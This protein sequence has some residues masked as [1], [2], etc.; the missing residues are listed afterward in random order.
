[1]KIISQIDGKQFEDE[2]TFHRSLKAHGFT[3]EKYYHKFFPKKDLFSGETLN[4]RTKEQY[5]DNDFNSKDN[6]KKWL[7]GQSDDIARTYCK[8]ILSKRKNNK[9]I[10]YSPSQVELRTIMSPSILYY[11]KLFGDYYKLCCELGFRNK[12]INVDSIE[13]QFQNKVTA[14]STIYVDSREQNWLKFD[15]PFEITSLP[16]GD[17]HSTLNPNC[18]IERK[19]LAD[20]ISTLSNKNLERFNYEIYKAKNDGK[21]IIVVIEDTLNNAQSFKH[22]PYISKKIKATPEYIFHNVRELIQKYDNLQFLFV[23]NREEMKRVIL[24]IFSSGDFYRKIDLQLAYD[25]KKI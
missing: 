6:L 10:L 18:F 16:Y 3:K 15:T 19:S 24:S 2:K 5:F 8:N 12:Y 7:K 9:N 14:R 25:S 4:F 17:Y 13:N 20:F 1:M 22:L 11:N 21:D 23:K